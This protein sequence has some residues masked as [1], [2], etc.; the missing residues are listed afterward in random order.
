MAARR[1]PLVDG[2]GADPSAPRTNP[3]WLPRRPASSLRACRVFRPQMA[4]K[5]GESV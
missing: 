2:P 5:H 3:A 4:F 1:R